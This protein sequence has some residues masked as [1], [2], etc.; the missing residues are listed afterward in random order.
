MHLVNLC[1][2]D[3][4]GMVAVEWKGRRRLSENLSGKIHVVSTSGLVL[5]GTIPR[6]ASLLYSDHVLRTHHM[7]FGNILSI[8]SL[9]GL[10]G[11]YYYLQFKNKKIKVHG[12]RMT[13]P[14]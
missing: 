13:C 12:R 14:K 9:A 4:D 11:R 7:P 6:R 10:G 3:M 5:N 1:S 2:S 8:D